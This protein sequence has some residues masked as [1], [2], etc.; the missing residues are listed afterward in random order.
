MHMEAY[1]QVPEKYRR[2]I[3]HPYRFCLMIVLQDALG[4]LKHFEGLPPSE[5][6]VTIADRQPKQ[7]GR[8]QTLWNFWVKQFHAE[9]RVEPIVFRSR[10][11]YPQLQAADLFA[12]TAFRG[13][14][15]P[16]P[17]ALPLDQ[18]GALFP[19]SLYRIIEPFLTTQPPP[20]YTG[21]L[22]Y[23][24]LERNF[25]LFEEL[26]RR[27]EEGDDDENDPIAAVLRERD[28]RK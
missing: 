24:V 11:D 26:L 25:P 18:P 16:N 12:H 7:E 15:R 3:G 10:K 2:V 1:R 27:M 20:H 19:L 5:R 4:Q 21:P 17:F 6:L 8:T 13:M 9:A 23:E 22:T 14:S 28:K